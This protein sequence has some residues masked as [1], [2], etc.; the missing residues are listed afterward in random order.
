[1]K[2]VWKVLY[3]CAIICSLTGCIRDNG[4]TT[5]D[6]GGV[7]VNT[8]TVERGDTDINQTT[9]EEEHDTG[10]SKD[11]KFR[12]LDYYIYVTSPESGCPSSETLWSTDYKDGEEYVNV[13]FYGK[14]GSLEKRIEE[15]KAEGK[16]VSNGWLW[17]NECQFYVDNATIAMVPLGDDGYLQVEITREDGALTEMTRVHNGFTMKIEKVE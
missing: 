13:D 7:D 17:G 15:L 6:R 11:V 2:R 3:V 8:T 12:Y 1:M 14:E 10:T 5:S 16:D 9:T 4:N